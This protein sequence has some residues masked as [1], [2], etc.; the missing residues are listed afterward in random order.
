VKQLRYTLAADGPSDRALLSVINWL[1]EQHL[2]QH[3]QLSLIT[4]LPQFALSEAQPPSSRKLIDR[5]SDA[6]RRFPCDILFVHRDAER[7]PHEMRQIE[8]D[9]AMSELTDVPR[10][11][12]PVIPVRMTE[13][14]LL[15]DE[16]SIRQAAD[17]PNG[18]VKLNLPRVSRLESLL[19]P[20][21][22][23]NDLLI[24]ASEK[25][26]RRLGK[27]KRASELAWRRGRVSELIED[28]GLL[29][30]LDAFNA[31]EEH[32]HRSI[33]QLLANG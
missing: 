22:V 32:L 3:Q 5:V 11:W 9:R 31:F 28:Y 24:A 7:E 12:V 4:V 13:A 8:I 6:I 20:K 1:L 16:R 33:N 17:N 26:G 10:A 25:T 27:F 14:W 18:S 23:L 15:I 19:D 21:E 30:S 29:R 2:G